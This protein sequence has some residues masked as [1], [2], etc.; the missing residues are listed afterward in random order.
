MRTKRAS[1]QPIAGF[2]GVRRNIEGN[3]RDIFPLPTR[4]PEGPA[5][6]ATSDYPDLPPRA[7]FAHISRSYLDSIHETYP[8]LR[9]PSFQSE[10]D[11]VYTARGLQGM[12]REWIGLF[13]AVMAC[14]HL[15]LPP[16]TSSP[17]RVADN[18]RRFYDIAVQSVTPWPSETA[19]IHAQIMFLLALYA[20]ESNMKTAGTMWLA[21][22]IRIAQCLGINFEDEAQ[23]FVQAEMHRRLWWAFYVRDRSV[24]VSALHR[25]H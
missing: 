4:Q 2:D 10:V 1:V 18:G 11:Q 9:W 19:V 8:V 5:A 17:L 20:T 23:S 22:G 21:S 6:I 16:N 24:M 13:F 25:T 3:S 7:D 12:P 14:G 15:S